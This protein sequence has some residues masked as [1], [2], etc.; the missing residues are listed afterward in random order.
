MT[1]TS[2]HYDVGGVL[3]PRPFKIR[4]FG[5]FGYLV[6][7]LDEALAFYT[8]L[9]GLSLTE[10]TRLRD[11]LPPEMR[12]LAGQVS[13]DRMFFTTYCGDHHSLLLSHSSLGALQGPERDTEITA[14]QITWQVGTLD[15][16]IDGYHFL[17]G[18]G[19]PILRVGRDMPGSNWHVYFTDPDGFTNEMYYGIEQIGW[20]RASKP[21]DM[22]YRGFGE[23]PARPQLPEWAEVKEAIDR[24]IDLG[25]GFRPEWWNGGEYDVGGVML[26]RPFKVT[27][28][29][30]VGL[31]VAD[32]GR[33]QDFYT[34]LL[35]F[36]VSE[37]AV[38][39][40]RR[41]VF[42]R[43]GPEHHS[44]ALYP[45]P[46]RAE[47][48]LSPH[49]SIASLGFEVGSYTQLRGALDYL[50]ERGCRTVELP[51]GFHPGI[52]YA[53]HVLDPD[54]HIT[55][56]YY[57][58]EQV[59]WDGKPRPAAQRRQASVPWPQTVDPLSDTYADQ[60]FMGPLG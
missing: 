56:L 39:S 9:L 43:H 41:C 19:V 11:L 55:Q 60:T 37:E 27:K 6:D 15:E 17:K 57:Y 2:A 49:S 24:G 44:L 5:H 35:G 28:I 25:S 59:G 52:D 31:F 51:S 7:H 38:I 48:G 16:V 45:K 36:E 22:Y 14:D 46:L 40:G 26:A 23:E 1:Q 13:D 32:V 21:R 47:L 53:A 20:S 50:L 3:L 10:A 4:R 18:E 12:H 42:L 34:R 29:G 30:P 54:G 8:G 33:S 58:M